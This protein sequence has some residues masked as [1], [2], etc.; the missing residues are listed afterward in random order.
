MKEALKEKEEQEQVK[1]EK[2]DAMEK[3]D[4]ERKKNKH[5]H[6]TLHKAHDHMMVV[7][8]PV[9]DANNLTALVVVALDGNMNM[10]RQN[11]M[12]G[13]VTGSKEVIETAKQ[14]EKAVED[15]GN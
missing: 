1:K 11:W 4:D 9:N 6:A 8:G 10:K 2:Q 14:T 3:A 7:V 13:I 15:N 12:K 5:L